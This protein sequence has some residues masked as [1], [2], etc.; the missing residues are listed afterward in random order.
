MTAMLLVVTASLFAAPAARDLPFAQGWEL[1]GD[2]ARV[3]EDGRDAIA[4]GTGWACRRD[5][6]L[7]DGTIELDVKVTRR[8][9]GLGRGGAPPCPR[10]RKSVV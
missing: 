4:I 10:D 5:V 9:E 3:A 1:R 6:Q 8:R 7:A 2:A